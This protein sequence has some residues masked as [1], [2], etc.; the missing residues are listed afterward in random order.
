M[1]TLYHELLHVQQ[2]KEFGTEYVQNNQRYFE[3]IT[4]EA[5]AMFVERLKKEG[6]L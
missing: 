4:E 1:R 2:F 3:D 5:E 6:L